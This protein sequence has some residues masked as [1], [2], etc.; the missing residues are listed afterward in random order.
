MIQRYLYPSMLAMSALKAQSLNYEKYSASIVIIDLEDSVAAGKKEAARK[1]A[2]NILSTPSQVPR[3]LRINS[4][5]TLTGLR[6]IIGLLE[7]GIAPDVLHI[8][9]V[10]SIGEVTVIDDL[11]STSNVHKDTSLG[12]VIETTKGVANCDNIAKSSKRIDSLV[13]GAADFA[14]DIGLPMSWNSL[15]HARSRIAFSAANAGIAAVDS[16]NFDLSNNNSLN[17]ELNS[18]KELGFSAKIAIHPHQIEPINDVFSEHNAQ[19]QAQAEQILEMS[20]N[21]EEPCFKIKNKMIGPPM[22]RQIKK[23]LSN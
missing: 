22:I 21:S 5:R 4:I 11:L 19:L 20:E 9:K 10:E 12:I 23:N 18:I 7:W 17:L 2:F 13:F 14:A 3:C 16:P 6:D 15:Y 8:P 1:I